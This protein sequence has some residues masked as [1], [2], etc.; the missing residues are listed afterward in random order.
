MIKNSPGP[1]LIEATLVRA[2]D[3]LERERIEYALMGGLASAVV[4]RP[5]RTRD[6]D[7]FVLPSRALPA[8][9]A[10]S[11]AGFRTERTDETWLYKA[12]DGGVLVDLIFRSKGGLILNPEI[13]STI[14]RCAASTKP[15]T[16]HASIHRG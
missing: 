1:R 7:L 2:V 11:R 8:L 13:F 6:L 14:S 9:A 4:G 12:W 3:A 15:R 10:L 5:R 16:S